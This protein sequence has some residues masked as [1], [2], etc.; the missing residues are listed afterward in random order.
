M[1]KSRWSDGDD[2]GI[3]GGG[4]EGG[5]STMT[6]EDVWWPVGLFIHGRRREYSRYRDDP[7]PA[8]S[9]SIRRCWHVRLG[10]FLVVVV[11]VITVMPMILP[12]AP[13]SPLTRRNNSGKT[14]LMDLFYDAMPTEHKKRTHFHAFMLDIHA[15]MEDGGWTGDGWRLLDSPPLTHSLDSTPLHSTHLP[16]TLHSSRVGIHKIRE[17][18]GASFDALPQIAQDL[19][20]QAWLLCFDEFQVCLVGGG[21]GGGGGG[22][23][24]LTGQPPF[25]CMH[26]CMCVCTTVCVTGHRHC[27][28]HDP[29]SSHGRTA[30]TWDGHGGHVQSTP[31]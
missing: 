21:T 20:A 9:L 6:L 14:M 13:L 25:E 1:V 24:R 3:R 27:G 29:S 19:V 2:D 28:R 15:R 23:R 17:N 7:C 11:V 22:R 16:S 4:G 30:T 31:G 10:S 8:G 18:R 12:V 26:A 5:W